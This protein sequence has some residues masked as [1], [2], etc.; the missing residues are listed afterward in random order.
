M[1]RVCATRQSFFQTGITRIIISPRAGTPTVRMNSCTA[2]LLKPGEVV[3]GDD[4][5]T[6][7][8]LA[9]EPD[10]P[11]AATGGQPHS[12]G[13]DTLPPAAHRPAELRVIHSPQSGPERRPC[14]G[15]DTPTTGRRLPPRPRTAHHGGHDD[16]THHRGHKG[17]G[18]ETARLLLEAGHTVWIGARDEAL[19][20]AAAVELGARFVPLDVTDDTS[21]ASA[22]ATIATSGT[23]LDIV[24]NNAGIANRRAARA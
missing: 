4:G 16:N 13:R 6:G 20:R 1:G 11:T 23:G 14:P 9:P 10:R 7:E 24:V 8:L 3:D 17:L 2:S 22:R 15:P 5:E 21:V 12:L 18:K 19:G